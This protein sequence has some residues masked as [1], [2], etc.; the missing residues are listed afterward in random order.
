M[1]LVNKA[2]EELNK[3]KE[4]YASED[5]LHDMAPNEHKNA[6]HYNMA[7]H[8][9]HWDKSAEGGKDSD[10]HMDLADVHAKA[11][12]AAAAHFHKATGKKIHDPG[13]GGESEHVTHNSKEG[14]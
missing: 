8:M 14:V 3:L 13:Y 10:H 2:V 5:M 9:H 1:S 4:S 7:M 6:Y 11:A 12:D